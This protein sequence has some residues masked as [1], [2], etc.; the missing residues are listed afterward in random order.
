MPGIY[1]TLPGQI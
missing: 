1:M